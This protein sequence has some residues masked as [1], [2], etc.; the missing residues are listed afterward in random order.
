V[1]KR[2][3]YKKAG[4]NVEAGARLV[5]RIEQLVQATLKPEVLENLGK[6]ASFFDLTKLRYKEP[7]LVSATDGVGTKL[8]IAQE[9]NKHDT[10]GIDL[11]AMCV[12]DVIVH[13]ADPLFFLDYIATDKLY[14]EK[15]AQIIKGIVEGCLEADCALIGGETAEMPGFY[16][17]NQYDLAGFVVGIVDKS[18]MITGAEIKAGDAIVGLASS[19]LHSN[20]YSLVRRL[21]KLKKISLTET[22]VAGV[23]LAEELLKPTFI[24]VKPVR[25]VREKF[26]ILGM[27][28]ITGGGLTHNLPRILPQN[29]DAFIDTSS[30]PKPAIFEFIKAQG[31]VETEEM[32]A[33]FNMGIGLVLVV[34]K[35][36]VAEVLKMLTQTG[37]RAFLIGEIKTGSGRVKFV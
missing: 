1:E 37:I 31:N 16:R 9:L 10:V 29:V 28:H 24:Y 4:V 8:K 15:M 5:S 33:T 2:L 21:I 13:G 17:K 35:K 32:L 14:P 12:N 30:W 26:D 3:T 20:G 7:V 22:R 23:P 18:S 11:V 36:V 25:A 34:R 19:G 27:A 6:F